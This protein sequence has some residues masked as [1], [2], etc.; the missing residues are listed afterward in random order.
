MRK[1]FG[2]LSQYAI[3]V[4][5]G[6]GLIIF[7]MSN[8]QKILGFLDLAGLWDP[9]LLFVMVGAVIVGLG[10]FML[11]AKELK[12]F[13]VVLCTFLLAGTSRSRS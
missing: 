2:L 13:L 5:F 12:P 11:S 7:G 1:H 3:G 6:W 9:S 10:V 4:L 8:P